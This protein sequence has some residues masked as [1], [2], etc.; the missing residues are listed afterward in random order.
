MYFYSVRLCAKDIYTY[1]SCNNFEFGMVPE[2]ADWAGERFL[3]GVDALVQLE[4]LLRAQTSDFR[5]N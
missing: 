2:V 3:A 4:L 1:I 5:K